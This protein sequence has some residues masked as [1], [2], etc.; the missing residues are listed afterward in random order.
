MQQIAATS[1]LEGTCVEA[2]HQLC[3]LLV[4]QKDPLLLRLGRD[5]R[6]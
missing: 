4:R 3:L 2:S 6:D 1:G 5:K